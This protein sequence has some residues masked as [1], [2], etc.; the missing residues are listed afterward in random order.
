MWFVVFALYFSPTL[1]QSSHFL[2]FNALPV[3]A[4]S[5]CTRWWM[6]CSWQGRS[7]RP[8]RPRS[9]SSSSCSS[10]W[11]RTPAIFS[12]C[13]PIG[14]PGNL[15]PTPSPCYHHSGEPAS[16]RAGSLQSVLEVELHNIVYIWI[17]KAEVESV[18]HSSYQWL[19]ISMF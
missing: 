12:I 1:P 17:L 6:R 3:S 14:C 5:R 13:P 10:H 15:N 11:S 8:V 16:K 7:G 9:S 19:Y 18:C 4:H 2:P